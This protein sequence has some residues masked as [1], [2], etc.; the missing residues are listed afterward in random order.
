M[1]IFVLAIW[2]RGKHARYAYRMA[3][4]MSWNMRDGHS[5]SFSSFLAWRSVAFWSLLLFSGIQ[6]VFLSS[7]TSSCMY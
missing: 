3:L 4:S 7:K 6:G 2:E 5:F 1:V